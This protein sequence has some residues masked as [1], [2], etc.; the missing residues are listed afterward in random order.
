TNHTLSKRTQI[1]D[2]ILYSTSLSQCY[3]GL[4]DSNSVKFIGDTIGGWVKSRS[5][6][7]DCS[8]FSGS[9]DGV[10]WRY[11]ASGDCST[12][13]DLTTIRGAIDSFLSNNVNGRCQQMCLQMNHGGTWNGY[14]S[15][16]P[17]GAPAPTDCG[18]INY[19]SCASYGG[20][21]DL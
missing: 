11:Y 3:A 14:L 6:S 2:C 10:Q 21:N 13:A 15:I 5:D 20:K 7:N 8:V 16:T 19:G 12:T 1:R 9:V 18:Q 4:S 17:A